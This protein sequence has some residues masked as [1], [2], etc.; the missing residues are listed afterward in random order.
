[1][2]GHRFWTMVL[3]GVLL[4]SACNSSESPEH[5]STLPGDVPEG[6]EVRRRALASRIESE[7]VSFK[8]TNPLLRLAARIAYGE[9]RYSRISSPLRGRVVD[10]RARLGD[11][12]EAGDVL[13]VIESPEITAVY[14]DY[15]KE[16]SEYEYAKRTYR[17]AKDLYDIKALPEKDLKQAENDLVKAQAEYRRAKELLMAFRVPEREL[18]KPLHEQRVTS[19][20]E[21]R[22]SITGTIVERAVTLGQS[23]GGDPSE[24]LFTVANLD[25][26]LVVADVYERDLGLVRVGQEAWVTVDAYPGEKFPASVFAIGDIVD[27]STRTIKV[28]AKVDNLGHRLKPEMFA[29]LEIQLGEGTPVLAL[30]KEAVLDMAGTRVVFVIDEDGRYVMRTVRVLDVASDPVQILEGLTPGERVVTKGAVLVKALAKQGGRSELSSED[31][32]TRGDSSL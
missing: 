16:A 1:M 4:L 21:L 11:H 12:V 14:S 25:V 17:L 6:A 15:I 30:P 28:R 29:R 32:G 26:L 18:Q 22:S 23:V 19:R 7:V 10:I 27:P 20:F 3:A 24:L 31:R 9:D 13:V 5:S 2:K 8:Q